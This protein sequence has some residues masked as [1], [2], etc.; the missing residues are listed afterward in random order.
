MDRARTKL[1]FHAE[2]GGTITDFPK[3]N[4]GIEGKKSR[5]RMLRGGL[6]VIYA[7]PNSAGSGADL[8]FLF[9]KRRN[10]K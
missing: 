3:Q 4:N 5:F 1:S 6:L 10:M 8:S 7:L 2:P 9:A